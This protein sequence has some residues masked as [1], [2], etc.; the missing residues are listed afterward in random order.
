MQVKDNEMKQ[1][2]QGLVP[3]FKQIL[4]GFEKKCAVLYDFYR[5]MFKFVLED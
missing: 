4:C 3:I 5:F 1:K 2:D